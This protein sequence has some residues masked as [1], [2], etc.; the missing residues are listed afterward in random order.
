M[1]W[2]LHPVAITTFVVTAILLLPSL[3]PSKKFKILNDNELRAIAKQRNIIS[4][5]TSYKELI[6]LLDTPLNPITH[7]KISL[8]KELFSDVLLSKDKTIS[9]ASCHKLKNGGDDNIPTAIGYH[10]L[11]NPSHLN[12]PTVLNSSLA[13]SLFWDGRAKN[14]ETQAKGPIQAPFEMNMTPKEIEDRLKKSTKYQKSFE[15][16]FGKNAISFDNAIKA[17]AV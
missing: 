5:P 16:V 3:L 10:H 8:G 15:K 6:R 9:C 13:S 17:I 12:T 7:D 2:Y 14:L 11:K 1:K 4:P